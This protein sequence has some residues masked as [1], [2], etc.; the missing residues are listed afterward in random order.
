MANTARSVCGYTVIQCFQ[1]KSG[2]N[3]DTVSDT[4]SIQPIQR[5]PIQESIQPHP[6]STWLLGTDSR[7]I[8]PWDQVGGA[9]VDELVATL[10]NNGMY[11][12]NC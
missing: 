3:A 12:V 7:G 11:L 10:R 5:I 8:E 6:I 9:R 4:K 1:P 2:Y